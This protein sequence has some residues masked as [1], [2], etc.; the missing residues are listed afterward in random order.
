MRTAC[1]PSCAQKKKSR[2]TAA[3]PAG[4]PEGIRTPGLPLRSLENSISQGASQCH[5]MLKSTVKSRELNNPSILEFLVRTPRIT[6]KTYVLS[7]VISVSS[8]GTLCVHI[9]YAVSILIQNTTE[10]KTL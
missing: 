4:V 3:F 10:Y 2:L 8:R 7:T 6:S 1:F 9:N 5:V